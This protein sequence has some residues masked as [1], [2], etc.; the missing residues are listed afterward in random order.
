MVNKTAVAWLERKIF[1]SLTKQ[2]GFTAWVEQIENCGTTTLAMMQQ[3]ILN[4]KACA[5]H[6]TSSM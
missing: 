1:C 4:S 6:F 5:S 2:L 3:K